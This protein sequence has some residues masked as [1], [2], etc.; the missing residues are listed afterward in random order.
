M[1][2]ERG[3]LEMDVGVFIGSEHN[4][5]SPKGLPALRDSAQG[6]SHPGKKRKLRGE[7]SIFFMKE[8]TR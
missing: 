3:S 6:G 7:E 8:N 5:R 1:L 2:S 4:S